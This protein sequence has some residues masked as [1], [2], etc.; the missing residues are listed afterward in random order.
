MDRK[1]K[2]NLV[3]CIGIG[4]IL[5]LA[6]VAFTAI[7][8]IIPIYVKDDVTHIALATLVSIVYVTIS[9]FIANICKKIIKGDMM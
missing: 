8:A 2:V 6:V 5:F 4:I 9:M 1:K 7:N 3:K